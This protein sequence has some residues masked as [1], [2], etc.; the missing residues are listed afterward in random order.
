MAPQM[1]ATVLGSSVFLFVFP[2]FTGHCSWRRCS[3]GQ[4]LQDAQMGKRVVKLHQRGF[5][6][7]LPSIHL[8]NLRWSDHRQNKNT[9]TLFESF[10]GTLIKQIPPVNCQNTDS[11]SHVPPETVI[12]WA[13]RYTVI[14]DTSYYVPRAAFKTIWSV[15]GSSHT[16]LHAEIKIW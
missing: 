13:H 16:N 2:I 15:F 4:T 12:Y 8:E 5:R 11:T 9:R 7:P 10:S 1:A 3:S 14:K 6:M